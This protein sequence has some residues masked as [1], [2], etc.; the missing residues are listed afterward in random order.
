[1]SQTHRSAS[2][3]HV[4]QLINYPITKATNI[5]IK[6]KH[7]F[8]DVVDTVTLSFKPSFGKAHFTNAVRQEVR[9]AFSALVIKPG[10]SSKIQ[11]L[12]DIPEIAYEHNYQQINTITVKKFQDTLEQIPLFSQAYAERITK[13]IGANTLH[14]FDLGL[15]TQVIE[16]DEGF[17]EFDFLFK[18]YAQFVREAD[19]DTE[20]LE[21]LIENKKKRG[22]D[23][24]TLADPI[25]SFVINH[26]VT[27][28]RTYTTWTTSNNI[29][30]IEKHRSKYQAFHYNGFGPVHFKSFEKEEELER[31][32]INKIHESWVEYGKRA[33]SPPGP[34]DRI[35]EGV[36]IFGK[37]SQRIKVLRLLAFLPPFEEWARSQRDFIDQIESL[38][39]DDLIA[40][41]RS[42]KT[43]FNMKEDTTFFIAANEDL[44]I[45][46]TQSIYDGI[47]WEM[48]PNGRISQAAVASNAQFP[49][50]DLRIN[51]LPTVGPKKEMFVASKTRGSNVNVFD[52]IQGEYKIK[53]FN[54]V[55]ST[56]GNNTSGKYPTIEDDIKTYPIVEANQASFYINQNYSPTS[57]FSRQRNVIAEQILNRDIA[58]T[59]PLRHR[60]FLQSLLFREKISVVGNV[61]LPPSKSASRRNVNNSTFKLAAMFSRFLNFISDNATDEAFT[62]TLGKSLKVRVLGA[63]TEPL[64]S[65]INDCGP[66]FSALG[67]GEEA[68]GLH[69]RA[70]I[71]TTTLNLACNLIISDIDQKS[72]EEDTYPETVLEQYS[73]ARDHL[74][75]YLSWGQYIIMKLNSPSPGFINS[76]VDDTDLKNKKFYIWRTNNQNPSTTE[77]FLFVTPD[78]NEGTDGYKFTF[79]DPALNASYDMMK[80]VTVVEPAK[81]YTLNTLPSRANLA[82]SQERNFV[83][84]D[85]KEQDVNEAVSYLMH[86]CEDIKLSKNGSGKSTYTMSGPITNRRTAISYR[87]GENM[88]LQLTK[89][90]KFS[91]DQLSL[92]RPQNQTPSIRQ[93]NVVPVQTYVTMY[94]R[95]GVMQ[96][97][98]KHA[99]QPQAIAIVGNRDMTGITTLLSPDVKIISIDKYIL[100]TYG[101]YGITIYDEYLDWENPNLPNDDYI[102]V[103]VTN[104]TFAPQDDRQDHITF[105]IQVKRIIDLLQSLQK[106][107]TDKKNKKI[108][109]AMNFLHEAVM[110][111]VATIQ[112]LLEIGL[113]VIFDKTRNRYS[114]QVGTYG[115]VELLNDTDYA[116]ISGYLPKDTILEKTVPI[117]DM[118]QYNLSNGFQYNID[119][120]PELMV[121]CHVPWTVFCS[122]G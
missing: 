110:K 3:T 89:R 76:L 104:V 23:F 47:R 63:I 26:P 96:W 72:V 68:Q 102:A 70:M 100:P 30:A 41:Y 50:D 9:N 22:G 55:L 87:L 49:R 20:F 107:I 35:T 16:G 109:L 8:T 85:V 77:A 64:I 66:S 36:G 27:E 75:R 67:L 17:S 43:I 84:I 122:F 19:H 86:Y 13:A 81:H 73:M 116:K 115:R 46:E 78:E 29:S 40:R 54:G 83:S 106:R 39:T 71:E 24:L 62:A 103:F 114:I 82:V 57:L 99:D 44:P 111:S 93:F 32:V 59:L 94:Q 58:G 92:M 11:S 65:I 95:H 45:L 98:M 113:D 101:S 4:T 88:F 112:D 42:Y 118:Q 31:Y 90:Q 6:Y 33:S 18:D 7:G 21:R 79:Q 37:C 14:L 119:A 2:S 97:A 53:N 61:L 25:T 12:N 38:S 52:S 5:E 51:G 60:V 10:R 56:I 69:V 121:W 105:D 108:Y 1:M 48:I 117:P 15:V 74:R 28:K 80:R 120:S 91:T 34:D